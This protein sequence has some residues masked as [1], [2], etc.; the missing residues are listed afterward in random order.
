M[1]S[2]AGSSEGLY[3]RDTRHLSHYY[4]TINGNVRPILLSSSL[5]DDNSVLTIDVTNPDIAGESGSTL[6]NDLLHIRRMRF[7]S[8]SR[9][10][11]RMTLTNYQDVPATVSLELHFASDF[12]DLFEVRGA[13]RIRRGERLQPAVGTDSV[14]LAYTGLDAITRQTRLSFSPAP[15][16]LARNQAS[17]RIELEPRKS[18]VVMV[19]I[20]CGAAPAEDEDLPLRKRLVRSYRSAREDLRRSS[21]RAT[22]LESTNE[23]LNQSLR[24]CVA[25]TYML[26][27]Q[28]EY[29]LYPYAGIPWYS[30]VFGRDALITALELLWLDPEIA[31]GVLRYLAANQAD[32]FDAASDAEPGKILHEV[33]YGEMAILGE[34]PFRHYYGSID[35]TPLFV[36]LAGAYLER[37]NDLETI[38]ALW[39]NIAR[40]LEW[41]DQFGDRDKD[42]YVEYGRYTEQG[43]L[44][45][46][47]KDSHDSIFHADGTIAKGPIALCEVQGYTYGAWHAAATI[48]ERRGEREPAAVFRRRA[49]ALRKNFDRDFFDE[50]LGTYVLALDGEKKPCRVRSSNA[51]QVLFTGLAL[52]HRAGRVAECL[53]DAG[54]FSGWGIRTIHAA[55]ARYNPMSYHNGSIWP[56]DNALIG[57]GLAR[58]GFRA[59]TSRIFEG[60]FAASTYVDLRRLPELFCGF[61]KRP[62]NGPTFYP[63]SCIPQAWSAAAQLSLVQ[64]C[65][66]LSI[67]AEARRIQFDQPMLPS[68]VDELKLGRLAVG[69]EWVD[70]RLQRSGSKVLVEVL[71]RQGDLKVVTSI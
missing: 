20:D 69:D 38:G 7:L 2:V 47:W 44:N 13:T 64:S 1:I 45:Q 14:L 9:L 40:A 39:P 67:D 23:V 66:G 22:S 61:V 63:V 11:E 59:E 12:A 58:Y 8:E 19:E 60:L 46:G 57:V 43:L 68:F 56:H 18:K 50:E 35:S 62:A 55:E 49:E 65:L 26:V 30:T 48:M 24:R 16:A 51:G 27:T 21:G 4:L 5:R 6:Q 37:T 31:K 25:D 15:T 33:R 36:M 42:G 53:M 54:S 71:E 17:F 70:L 29:G 3:H 32:R 10:Y 41:I 34:V 28:T 52:P